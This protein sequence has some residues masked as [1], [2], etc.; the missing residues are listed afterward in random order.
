MDGGWFGRTDGEGHG[1][2]SSS[3]EPT[4]FVGSDCH[5][6]YF[7]RGIWPLSSTVDPLRAAHAGKRG[8]LHVPLAHGCQGCHE[9]QETIPQEA[10]GGNLSG[11]DAWPPWRLGPRRIPSATAAL[12]YGVVTGAVGRLVPSSSGEVSEAP[13]GGFLRTKHLLFGEFEQ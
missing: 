12:P 6:Q 7:E 1:G 5:F 10:G 4:L 3:T 2:L 9:E 8:V 11:V 13:M